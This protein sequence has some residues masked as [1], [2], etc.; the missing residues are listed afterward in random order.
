MPEITQNATGGT[1]YSPNNYQAFDVTNATT[2]KFKYD[3]NCYSSYYYNTGYLSAYLGY[4]TQLNSGKYEHKKVDS[5]TKME[6]IL[7]GQT[8]NISGVSVTLD[9]TKYTTMVF[10]IWFDTANSSS[11]TGSIRI[12]DI[13]IN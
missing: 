6:T 13:E 12:Y 10:W 1:K 4:G 3:Y 9:V 2:M 11:A 5:S 7:S 8:S